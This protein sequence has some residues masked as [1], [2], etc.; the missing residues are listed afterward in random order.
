MSGLFK[1]VLRRYFSTALVWALASLCVL[2]GALFPA[3]S[4]YAQSKS[5]WAFYDVKLSE[6]VRVGLSQLLNQSFVADDALVRDERRVTL[7][8]KADQADQAGTILID[9][10]LDAGYVVTQKNGLWKIRSTNDKDKETDNEILLYRPRYRNAGYFYDLLGI[11]RRSGAASSSESEGQ[12]SSSSVRTAD[13]RATGQVQARA[14]EV[15]ERSNS[16]TASQYIDRGADVVYIKGTARE[17]AT[18]LAAIKQL[19]TPAE[20]IDV[21]TVVYEYTVTNEEQTAFGAILRLASG[22]LSGQIGPASFAG[23]FLRFDTKN[24]SVIFGALAEDKRFHLLSNPSLRTKSGTSARI[25][26]GA[27]VP[28]LASTTTS[29]GTTTQNVTYQKTGVILEL[30]PVVLENTIDMQVK[31]TVSEAV[32]TSTGVNN[33]PTL[34]TR[35]ITTGVLMKDEE[36]IVIGGL[37]SNKTMRGDTGIRWLPKY[38]R[39]ND[40][41][42]NRTE[43]LVFLRV[44]KVKPIGLAVSDTA[45]P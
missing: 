27:D 36:T 28:T 6:I 23:D 45:A 25:A 43:L 37:T 10:L 15:S 39:A 5:A 38:L 8:L 44:S 13:G 16:D 11:G 3:S 1:R 26:I 29:N 17:I 35:E 22:K 31:Q 4:A 34:T 9:L 24:L 21:A 42:E 14:G 20:Q 32:A 40:S 2:T 7:D 12:R 41:S 18:Y 30:K 19:D 33:S